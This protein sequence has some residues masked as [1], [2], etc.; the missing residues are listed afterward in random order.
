[1]VL[2]L[3]GCH[4][5][6]KTASSE[7]DKTRTPFFNNTHW[8]SKKVVAAMASHYLSYHTLSARVHIDYKK[9]GAAYNNITAYLRMAKDSVIWLSVRPV[10][11]IEMARLLITPDSVKIR[12]NLK[13]TVLIRSTG[14]LQQLLGIPFRFSV[15][16]SL[17]T[18]NPAF[19]PEKIL[20]L[21]SDTAAIYATLL[22]DSILYK[23]QWSRDSFRLEQSH[24]QMENSA[25]FADQ[26]FS[27][28]QNVP[29]G[30]FAYQRELRTQTDLP[31][32]VSLSFDKVSFDTPLTFPF[33]YDKNDTR[34]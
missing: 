9:G 5:S 4:T 16:E 31:V 21:R 30:Q 22:Q 29:G 1:M 10:L 6:R 17:L 18:G 24:Y 13:K 3:L 8:S 2:I 11:G 27:A 15:L 25:L 14:H 12:N 26:Q 20:N 19:I 23:Y 34:E 28:Y 7:G 32:E 33:S